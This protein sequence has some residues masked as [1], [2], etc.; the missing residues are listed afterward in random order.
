MRLFTQAQQLLKPPGITQAV[1]MAI[2]NLDIGARVSRDLD[3]KILN[4]VAAAIT[5]TVSTLN[6]RLQSIIESAIT[7]ALKGFAKNK[8]NF[9]IK[10]YCTQLLDLQTQAVNEIRQTTTEAAIT[11]NTH[12]Y[13]T[14][15]H[16]LVVVNNALLKAEHFLERGRDDAMAVITCA[17]QQPAPG[18][19]VAVP[20]APAPVEKTTTWEPP[21][22]Q[23]CSSLQDMAAAL[24]PNKT[25]KGVWAQALKTANKNPCASPYPANPYNRVP[26][27]PR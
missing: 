24:D 11:F 10:P 4:V 14:C 12:L 1:L 23:P 6:T 26:S 2:E 3:T 7:L 5:S 13:A 21:V 19:P 20:S 27:P 17:Q 22:L 8:L 15:T 16:R 25:A 9:L 18:T